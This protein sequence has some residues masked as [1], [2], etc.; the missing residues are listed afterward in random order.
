[1]LTNRFTYEDETDGGIHFYPEIKLGEIEERLYAY[2]CLGYT[3]SELHLK[4]AHKA[5]TEICNGD[6]VYILTSEAAIDKIT[7]ADVIGVSNGYLYATD[8]IKN[9]MLVVKEENKTWFKTLTDA[10]K[11]SIG[12]S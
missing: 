12:L 5:D 8:G 3:P 7:I 4:I 6:K 10:L 2:E 11:Y 1:M 9:F